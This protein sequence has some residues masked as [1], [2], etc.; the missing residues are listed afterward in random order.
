MK[1]I[2]TPILALA[3][4]GLVTSSA[5]ANTS[6]DYWT[7][8]PLERNSQGY[9]INN[10][11]PSGCRWTISTAA[12]KW[13]DAQ[14]NFTYVWKGYV[15]PQSWSW[16]SFQGDNISTTAN[17]FDT[18]FEGGRTDSVNAAAQVEWRT[19][20]YN[21]TTGRYVFS[22]GDVVANYNRFSTDLWCS[23]STTPS[24]MYDFATIALH[25]MGHVI[26]LEHDGDDTANTTVVN[27]PLYG[28][29]MKRNLTARDVQRAVY[30]YGA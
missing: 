27:N 29:M 12:Q 11:I 22:D 4:C 26:G 30:L 6:A 7:W 19:K 16:D 15:T 24:N 1:H 5:I 14:L 25:E 23:S 8:G 9:W 20:S 13:T 2:T 21:A 18:Q 3:V 28:G 17:N 10:N